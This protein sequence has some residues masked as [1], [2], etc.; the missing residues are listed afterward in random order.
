MAPLILVLLVDMPTALINQNTD[1]TLANRLLVGQWHFL[2]TMLAFLGTHLPALS[3][4]SIEAL[5]SSHHR[6]LQAQVMIPEDLLL[7]DV[8]LKDLIVELQRLLVNEFVV[9]AFA[10]SR[11]N[12]VAL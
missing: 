2:A 1:S 3:A 9:E 10:V 12:D 5:A 11:L 8:L 7:D 6:L 4:L